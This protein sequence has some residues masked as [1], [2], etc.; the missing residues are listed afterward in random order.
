M[1]N[2]KKKEIISFATNDLIKFLLTLFIGVI[3]YVFVDLDN[4][5]KEVHNKLL[6]LHT[7]V[8][9]ISAKSDMHESFYRRH[10]DWIKDKE[11]EDREIIRRKRN[12]I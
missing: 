5:I 6:D 4:S 2:E 7:K 10:D 11:K 1:T 9:S 8:E 3:S 12:E